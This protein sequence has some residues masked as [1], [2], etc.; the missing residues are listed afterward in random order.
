MKEIRL[1]R[2]SALGPL[3]CENF[4]PFLLPMLPEDASGNMSF[5]SSL[6]CQGV[7]GAVCV[8]VVS[9]LHFLN[10]FYRSHLLYFQTVRVP[11]QNLK[12]RDVYLALLVSLAL[13]S[14]F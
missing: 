7:P 14:V 11:F 9:P 12:A 4:S 3:F 13:F 8:L 10:P 6:L 1:P 2:K 5:S